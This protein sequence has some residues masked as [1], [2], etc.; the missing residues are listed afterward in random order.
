MLIHNLAALAEQ[1]S[2]P[3]CKDHLRAAA[4]LERSQ[5][6]LAEL[7]SAESGPARG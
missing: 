6:M 2:G 3:L 5:A 1:L 4:V 7:E